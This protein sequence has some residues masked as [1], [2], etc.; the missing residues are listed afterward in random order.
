[1]PRTIVVINP[2]NRASKVPTI[3]TMIVGVQ[4]REPARVVPPRGELTVV[5]DVDMVATFCGPPA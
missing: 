1:M 4:L 3:E 2:K 5:D